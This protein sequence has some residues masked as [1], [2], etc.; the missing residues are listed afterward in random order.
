MTDEPVWYA[1][2]QSPEWLHKFN[3]LFDR[4]YA[5]RFSDP[6][7]AFQHSLVKL[8]MHKLPEC[9]YR[10][11]E[12][13]DGFVK[14]LFSRAVVDRC[15]SENGRYQ[16]PEDLKRS[17]SH[18]DL[19]YRHC[20]RGFTPEDI[21]R[22]VGL[23][24]KCVRYWVA[25]IELKRLCDRGRPKYSEYEPD[26]ILI[27]EKT[28]EHRSPEDA[29]EAEERRILVKE[30]LSGK[31]TVSLTADQI[32]VLKLIYWEEKTQAETAS[33]LGRSER[34]V[35]YIKEKAI[36]KLKKAVGEYSLNVHY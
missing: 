26:D 15:R 5:F 11:K 34:Q 19:F 22:A 30:L 6:Q 10:P 13:P 20:I 27:T 18:T 21:S 2:Y 17:K 35:K 33:Q 31:H 28:V 9:K 29:L 25:R 36:K 14:V 24:L 3:S 4:R 23:S 12:N 8:L 1:D 32:L 16:V 7:D